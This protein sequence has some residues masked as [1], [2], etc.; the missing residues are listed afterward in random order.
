MP[1]AEEVLVVLDQVIAAE[2]V[3]VAVLV[4]EEVMVAVQRE[5]PEQQEFGDR[6]TQVIPPTTITQIQLEW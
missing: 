4:A 1:E 3:M 2:E 5:L 6:S